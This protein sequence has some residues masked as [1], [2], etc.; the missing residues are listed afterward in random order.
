MPGTKARGSRICTGN[1]CRSSCWGKAEEQPSFLASYRSSLRSCS[2]PKQATESTSQPEV[3]LHLLATRLM[4]ATED[5]SLSAVL[6]SESSYKPP[7]DFSAAELYRSC[8]GSKGQSSS[9]L[10]NAQS[11]VEGLGGP[12]GLAQNTWCRRGGSHRSQRTRRMGYPQWWSK[13]RAPA[14]PTSSGGQRVGPAH[15]RSLTIRKNREPWHS[16]L[17]PSRRLLPTREDQSAL[18]GMRESAQSTRQV[19]SL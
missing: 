8:G 19:L 11:S 17:C 12:L 1:Q 18:R 14:H 5:L 15:L 7:L 16:Q 10:L 6:G 13:G 2:P 4:Q 3:Q 9:L